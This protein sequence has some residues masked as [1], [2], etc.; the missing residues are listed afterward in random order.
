MEVEFKY[1]F[2]FSIN[3]RQKNS[4]NSGN[5]N[6]FKLLCLINEENFGDLEI[7]ELLKFSG[8]VKA[9]PEDLNQ[10]ENTYEKII[11]IYEIQSEKGI[12]TKQIF[13]KK[14]LKINEKINNKNT[15]IE[16][17]NFS[18]ENLSGI[19]FQQDNINSNFF[20]FKNQIKNHD[21]LKFQKLSKYKCLFSFILIN[22]LDN[23]IYSNFEFINLLLFYFAFSKGTD[24]S[25]NI[26]DLTKQ[27]NVS[28]Q[29]KHIF[30][31][32]SN[33][34]SN[35]FNFNNDNKSNDD[36]L[37]MKDTKK[38]S[39]GEAGNFELNFG[40]IFTKKND[41]I[42][43]DQ[44]PLNLNSNIST[45]LNYGKCLKNFSPSMNIGI[46]ENCVNQKIDVD[47][48]GS[49]VINSKINNI[50]FKSKDLQSSNLFQLVN[51]YDINYF[52]ADRLDSEKDRKKTNIIL[53][54]QFDNINNNYNNKRKFKDYS[55]EPGTQ[56]NSRG[57]LIN[58]NLNTFE[59]YNGN[60]I[61]SAEEILQIEI[62]SFFS[63][64]NS[65]I[66]EDLKII[67]SDNFLNDIINNFNENNNT[68]SEK[69]NTYKSFFSKYII[70]VNNFIHPRIENKIYEE[71]NLLAKS[72]EEIFYP[73][74]NCDFLEFPQI[75][76]LLIKFSFIRARVDM[77]DKVLMCDV[78][79]SF[80][81]VKEYLSHTLSFSLANRK[82]MV[83]KNKRTKIN[84]VMEKIRQLCETE[85]KKNF[86]KKEVKN[87]CE[88]I[89]IIDDFDNIIE[90]LNFQGFMIK[91]SGDEF[92]LN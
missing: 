69:E 33:S 23:K 61:N 3:H 12:L 5:N 28:N 84:F 62:V 72:L 26:F 8:I 14:S 87:F 52:Y 85:A 54:N 20:F 39:R 76:K 50:A 17:K 32:L 91:I 78:F 65:T 46:N 44:I 36:F 77:R 1:N 83:N 10:Y 92:Q 41:F 6:K 53:K 38:D 13:E 18:Y 7:G 56:I 42:L 88:E 47:G 71:I 80:L 16:N 79:E 73:I 57:N 51:S 22:I 11:E 30:Q 31:I 67:R 74:K 27:D 55:N 24:L 40:E 81:F 58:E 49:L 29:I 59:V 82:E 4:F 86:T 68:N 9:K 64:L 2:D 45:F 90:T 70:F 37:I 63:Y 15:N 19:N 35:Y 25:I 43:L 75:D 48:I 21:I 60:L 34:D 89:N 66:K